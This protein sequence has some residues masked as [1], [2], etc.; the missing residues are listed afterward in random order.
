M[1]LL[2]WAVRAGWSEGVEYLSQRA[3]EVVVTDLDS[4]I[5]GQ[6]FIGGWMQPLWNA[7]YFNQ[8][9]DGSS[10]AGTF[11][12][13]ESNMDVKDH[14]GCTLLHRLV[15]WGGKHQS[16]FITTLLR[17]GANPNIKDNDNFTALQVAC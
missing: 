15:H 8:I 10:L 11:L 13:Q 16:K 9:G 2:P 5:I 12:R 4:H 6:A 3:G 14:A 7:A 17:A 1:G